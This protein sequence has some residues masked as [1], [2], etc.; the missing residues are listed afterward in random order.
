MYGLIHSALRKMVIDDQGEASWQALSHR[1]GIGQETMLTMRAYDDSISYA[2]FGAAAEHLECP[3][4]TALEDFGQ[5]WICDFAP[6]YYG[7]LLGQMGNDPFDFIRH[8]N[9]LHDRIAT[10]FPEFR[11]PLF[12]VETLD[13]HSIHVHYRSTR[14]GLTP[15]V[16]GLLAGLERRFGQPL[17]IELEQTEEVC[18]GGEH[19]IFR[20]EK[21][22]VT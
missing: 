21:V 9:D 10:A 17:S 16:S 14:R 2:L 20:I 15:F 4:H 5:Y 11:P 7:A 18:D 13:D 3:M 12:D 8:L 19:S 1:A 6:E 22:Q